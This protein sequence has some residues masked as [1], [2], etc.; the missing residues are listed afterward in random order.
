MSDRWP[1]ADD[2][3]AA[4]ITLQ[5][6]MDGS[7]PVLYVVHDEEDGTWQ[8][9]DGNE[10]SESDAV[11]VSLSNVVEVDPSLQELADLP[12]GWRAQRDSPQ[13]LWQRFRHVRPEDGDVE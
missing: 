11:V 13:S 4:T 1:F 3:N 6:I 12:R 8:F 9:L 5:R 7:E 2:K 10:V